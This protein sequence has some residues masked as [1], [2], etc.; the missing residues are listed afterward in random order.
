ILRFQWPVGHMDGGLCNTVHIDQPCG[1][2]VVL[3][4]PGGEC[5]NIKGFPSEDHLPQQVSLPTLHLCRS[6]LPEGTERLV[7][8]R[9]PCPAKQPIEIFRRTGRIPGHN[10]KTATI[11]KRAPDLPDREIESVRMEEAPDIL[12]IELEPRVS[13]SK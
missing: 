8:D 9:H 12:G 10:Y 6:Q 13:G 11:E 1:P 3:L 4:I 7:Q 5:G 2:A